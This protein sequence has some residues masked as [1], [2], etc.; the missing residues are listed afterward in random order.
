MNAAALKVYDA[1]R[2]EGTQKSV[3]DAMRCAVEPPIE[4]WRRRRAGKT[5][6]VVAAAS[7]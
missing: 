1:I 6:P 2:K 7:S 3:V 4:L 5:R